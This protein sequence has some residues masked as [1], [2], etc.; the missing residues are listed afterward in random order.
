MKIRFNLI[1]IIALV[2]F[3][4][5]ERLTSVINV[6]DKT[7][8]SNNEIEDTFSGEMIVEFS[9]DFA[10]QLELSANPTKSVSAYEEL[11]AVGIT[12]I[13]RLFPDAGE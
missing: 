11:S 6:E 7:S 9:E 10:E 13:E 3:S 1:V 4:C 2:S 12:E 8:T 5:S